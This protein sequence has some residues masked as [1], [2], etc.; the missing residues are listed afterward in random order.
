MAVQKYTIDYGV[1]N[2]QALAG[3]NQLVASL[4]NVH[5]AAGQATAAVQGVG[6]GAQGGAG[7]VQE[8][9]ASLGNLAT[10][11][12]GLRIGQE[13]VRGIT[14]A[15]DDALQFA[16]RVAEALEK[17]NKSVRELSA[18]TG[19]G[20]TE[21]S[22]KVAE[23]RTRTGMS[24][25]E[26]VKFA[27]KMVGDKDVLMM[28]MQATAMAGE[29]PDQAKQR[30]FEQMGTQSG[31]LAVMR[32]YDAE[33]ASL[34][35]VAVAGSTP[36]TDIGQ[37]EAQIGLTG[38]NIQRGTMDI[39]KGMQQ[40]VAAAPSLMAMKMAR[41][42]PEVAALSSAVALGNKAGRTA[43][44]EESLGV[45]FIKAA[46]GDKAEEWA[47]IGVDVK[48][49]GGANIVDMIEK[50]APALE[51][52]GGEAEQVNMLR[53]KFGISEAR[54]ALTIVKLVSQRKFL[55]TLTDETRDK[56]AD[57]AKSKAVATGLEA[58]MDAFRAKNEGGEFSEAMVD[59]AER[60]RGEEALPFSQEREFARAQ[61]TGSRE[62]GT[63]GAGIK[64]MMRGA[65]MAPERLIGRDVEG[66]EDQL[67]SQ[68]A[69]QNLL[70]VVGVD[71]M[72]REHPELLF[73]EGGR[74]QIRGDVGRTEAAAAYRQYTQG[75]PDSA[76][77]VR[78]LARIH[79]TIQQ[80]NSDRRNLARAN[81]AG[82]RPGPAAPPAGPA[83]R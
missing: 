1:V 69:M 48:A 75:A 61:L 60:E 56:L 38:E 78:G 36:V 51:S 37:F 83:R 33:T 18:M 76:E 46:T 13:I 31:R 40:V 68:R 2:Q 19:E 80:G 66:G 32:G 11:L 55:K 73:T 54:N 52:A 82:A 44:L 12:V 14:Q 65:I 43:N 47:G 34:L 71:R 27:A 45:D 58:Q 70:D 74:T 22:L 10:A 9:S 3:N 4:Q 64:N 24:E 49:E 63:W 30:L 7:G 41:S 26:A 5:Q 16:D 50:I 57:P 20:R 53:G 25:A 59:F 6:A 28:N 81:R 77:I 62:I 21:T 8:F 29:T 72:R 79:D 67:I 35:N 39:K 42:V 17:T 23:E 15:L